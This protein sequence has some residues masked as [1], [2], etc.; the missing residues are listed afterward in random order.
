MR[1]ATRKTPAASIVMPVFD[2]AP[3]VRLAVDSV[4]NQ[5]FGDFELIVVDD[6]STDGSLDTLHKVRDSRLRIIS[7][8][9][10]GSSAARNTGIQQAS[11]PYISFIDGDDLWLP[12]KLSTH[13]EFMEGH[14]E[15]DL[16]F[17]HS[18][19]IDENGQ[20]TGRFS[21]RVSGFISFEQLLVE[22]VVANGSAVVLR[23][24]V[25]DKAGHF[26]VTL[27]AAVDH[28]VWLRV[29]LTRSGNVYCIPEVL[30][31]YRLRAGQITKDWRR[32]EQSVL[33]LIQK[34]RRLAPA[35][36]ESVEANAR[37]NLY[38]YLAYIA[39]EK[40]EY[41][42]SGSLLRTSLC[43]GIRDLIRDRRTW[44][45]SGALMTRAILPANLHHR[46]DRFARS[47]RS[48]GRKLLP[49]TA[50]SSRTS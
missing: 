3:F 39:Y 36:V 20:H 25:L 10:A 1:R 12:Q 37:A 21:R 35:Q 14:P 43:H 23:R 22:N 40:G 5:S 49:F 31:L 7:Q 46:L 4:L 9:N 44:L 24:E 34:M 13:L 27:L 6:G 30:N 48:S 8:A 45:L 18:E 26:D 2:V 41:S 29:A 42:E 32:M 50:E 16:T 47:Y 38:R 19:V 33:A 28:D 15:V 11:A 17:S